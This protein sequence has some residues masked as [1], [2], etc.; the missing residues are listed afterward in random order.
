[1]SGK[2]IISAV[3]IILV[4][5]V[6]LGVVA[7]VRHNSDDSANLSPKMKAVTNFCSST[8]YQESCQKTLSSV[9]STEPKEFVAHA[10]LAAEQAVKKFL[11]Y[12]NSL[13]VQ[14]KN[15]SRT[16]MAFDDCKDMMDYAVDSL[17]ASYSQV[18]NGELRSINDRIGDIRTWLSAVISY[19][20]TCLDGFDHDPS[21]KQ[22]MKNGNVDARELTANALVIV[23]KLTDI[24]SKFG[25]QLNIPTSTSR[26]LFS[27]DKDGYPSWF[28]AADRKLLAKIDN[29][30]LK[31]NAVVAKDGSGQFKSIAEAIAAAPKG[32]QARHVIYVKA[33]VYDEYV[34]VD[35]KT[36]N[37]LMYGDG[38]RKTIVTGRK[39]NKGGVNTQDTATFTAIGFGF[40]ARSMGFQNTAGPEGH[41]AV[42]LR[43]QSDKSAFFNCRMDGYQDTLYNHANRQ[44]YRNCVISGTIDF[45]FGDS[46][47][48]IQNSLI[49]VRRPMDNQFNTVTAQGKEEDGENSVTVI[50][51]CRIV[52]EQKLFADRFKIKTYLGRPWKRF[53]TTIIMESILGDFIQPEGWMPWQGEKFEDT[54][55]Y[56]EYN[57]RGPGANLARRVNWKGYHKI[58]KKTAMGFTL[59]SVLFL[60]GDN[61]LAPTG[62]PFI[63]LFRY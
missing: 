8:N 63:P 7:V 48:F 26:R 52:P 36:V 32:S 45:I 3:S 39:S 4:V 41:Q 11:N 5:G 58:D 51:N 13:I 40:I 30:N 53:A 19:Q 27:V 20:E 18:G 10:I 38:P 49:I 25:L 29:S 54:V 57:N 55:Y 24:L 1:M 33:G 35:K 44:F 43:V 14:A 15:E 23:T 62:I 50:Q 42:A 46:P 59:Q 28:S 37:I 61:W 9:N 16:K 12:S 31:P 47:T 2:V 21:L 34:F 6:V 60:G 22:I 17:Q 56:A